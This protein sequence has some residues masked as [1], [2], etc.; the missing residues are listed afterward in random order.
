MRIGTRIREHFR[1]RV[2]YISVSIDVS[3]LIT[4]Y[5]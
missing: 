1:E 2:T 5:N 4:I 3:V